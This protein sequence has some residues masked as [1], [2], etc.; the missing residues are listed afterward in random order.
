[1]NDQ[2]YVDDIKMAFET[3]LDKGLN[4]AFDQILLGLQ[5]AMEVLDDWEYADGLD[6]AIRIVKNLK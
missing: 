3:G 2:A 4:L 5:E 6:L 1:M